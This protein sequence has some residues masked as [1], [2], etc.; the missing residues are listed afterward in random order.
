MAL[1]GVDD[2]ADGRG[3]VRESTLVCADVG[4]LLGRGKERGESEDG[5]GSR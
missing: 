1:V 4:E 2:A 5:R 3:K